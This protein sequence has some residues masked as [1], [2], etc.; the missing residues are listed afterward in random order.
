MIYRYIY[1]S[2][3]S[4][5]QTDFIINKLLD[6]RRIIIIGIVSDSKIGGPLATEIG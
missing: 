1:I 4:K 5:T 6:R 2:D 3:N